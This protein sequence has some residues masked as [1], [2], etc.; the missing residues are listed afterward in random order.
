[1]TR[2]VDVTARTFLV[3][4]ALSFLCFILMIVAQVAYRYVGVSMVFS[5]EAARL[6][7]IY[8]VFFGLVYVVYS[9]ADVR[10]N[11]IDALL[12]ANP[13]LK[14]AFAA[15]YLVVAL[16]FLATL[17]TGSYLLMMSNWSWPLPSIPFLSKGHIYLAPF[18]GGTVSSL[19]VLFRLARLFK[20]ELPAE[21][22]MEDVE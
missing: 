18:I 6:C 2:I 22:V 17:S 20:G 11:L 4:A 8:A 13:S 19:I 7:N 10:I 9:Y 16:I 12:D 3:L 5:E 1:M 21:L 15:F 14:M